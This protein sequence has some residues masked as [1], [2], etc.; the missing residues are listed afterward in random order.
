ML[1]ILFQDKSHKHKH[2]HKHKKS[3]KSEKKKNP[4]STKTIE[5]LR[6]ERLRRE[7]EERQKVRKLFSKGD[8]DTVTEEPVTD[9]NRGYNSAYNPDFVRKPKHKRSYNGKRL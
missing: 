4:S 6:A 5:Q 7:Q 2:K 3:E 8:E 9:R 1:Y